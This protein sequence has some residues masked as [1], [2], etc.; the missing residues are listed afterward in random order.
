MVF[1]ANFDPRYVE[2]TTLKRLFY[3]HRQFFGVVAQQRGAMKTIEQQITDA[4][5]NLPKPRT[6]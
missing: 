2:E 5:A 3:W 1:I 6:H 4:V